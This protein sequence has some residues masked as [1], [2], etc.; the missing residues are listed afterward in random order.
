MKKPMEAKKKITNLLSRSLGE[1]KTLGYEAESSGNLDR[2][3]W[4]YYRLTS[5]LD[6]VE[7][8][9]S[10][11][12]QDILQRIAHFYKQ[13]G[14]HTEADRV[15][16][17]ILCLTPSAQ[18]TH[19]LGA[20]NLYREFMEKTLETACPNLA[21]FKNILPPLH[22]LVACG[23]DELCSHLRSSTLEPSTDCCIFGRTA[24][25]AATEKGSIK[26]LE[27]LLK[28]RVEIDP[29]DSFAR[30]P[31]FLAASLGQ[32]TAFR[33]LLS[34]GSNLEVRDMASHSLMETAARG[35]HVGI[36][37]I[38]FDRGCDVNE[39]SLSMWGGCTPLHAA[40]ENGCFKAVNFLVMRGADASV[41]NEDR[42]TADKVAR[43]NGFPDIAE[44]LKEET[45]RRRFSNL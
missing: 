3:R 11:E 30:T 2:A 26:F 5:A 25:H 24:L 23:N 22:R 17:K 41:E 1:M 27:Q 40:A 18:S 36:M 35:N 19:N 4:M 42:Q 21:E 37:E 20:T 32:E 43:I 28:D 45:N 14:D 6:R 31:L 8:F 34:R 39:Q 12:R 44:F 38:L 29:R 15:V 10:F 9:S 16:Q 13:H 33:Y 7:D